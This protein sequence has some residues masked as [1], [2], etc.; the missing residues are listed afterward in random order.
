MITVKGKY[1]TAK[2]MIDTVDPNCLAQINSFVNHS[3]FTNPVAIM[4]DTHAGMGSVIGF[5]MPLGPRVIPNVVGVDIGCGMLSANIGPT[6]PRSLE[7]L[8]HKIRAQVPFGHSTHD[9]PLVKI[10]NG[11]P[12]HEASVLGEKFAVEY[13]QRFGAAMEIPRYS[14]QWFLNTCSRIGGQIRRYINSLGTLG[15]GNHFIETGVSEKGDHWITIHTGSRNLGK[16]ICEYWQRR[17]QKSL[18]HLQK[19][20]MRDEIESIRSR[21]DGEDIEN[22]IRAVRE[23]Y[24]INAID[25][26]GL[27]WLEGEAACEYLIDMVF[28]QVYASVN[29]RT[30]LSV[31]MRIL[32]VEPCDMI[33]TVHNYID[34]EDFV[35]RKGAIRS[36]EGERM[37]IPFNMRDGLL[38]CMGKSNPVWNNSAPHGAGRVMSRSEA[39]KRLDVGEFSRQMSGIFSTSVGRG[40][41]D[42]CPN[43]YKPAERIEEAIQETAEIVERVKPLHNMKD[44]GGANFSAGRRSGKRR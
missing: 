41:L 17:A 8:D 33:E 12:W 22:H 2:V 23:N 40:T 1:T 24:G 18:K 20:V 38:I 37:I 42:E 43:A 9:T 10:K 36:Y 15:G 29:R 39:R 16:R 34:F 13:R 19:N 11:F 4:P 27:E 3:A 5:T 21:Y 32:G 6:L 7:E 30:I 44:G 25:L 26:K 28:S 31:I 14:E 35:I